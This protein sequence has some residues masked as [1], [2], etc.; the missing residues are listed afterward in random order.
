MTPQTEAIIYSLNVGLPSNVD[1]AEG[2][3]MHSGILKRPVTG[4]VHLGQLG[5]DGD[6]SADRINHGGVDKAICVYCHDHYPYWEKELSKKLAPGAFGENLTMT[7]LTEDKVHIGDIYSI[8]TAK[9]QCSQPRQ[10]CHKLNKIYGLPDMATRV[11]KCGYTGFYLRVLEP[12][13]VEPGSKMELLQ[14]GDEE[15]SIS[16]ANQLMYGHDKWSFDKLRKIIA[17]KFLSVSWKDTFQSRLESRDPGNSRNK[18]S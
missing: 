12:G 14:K 10:P 7:A 11:Q 9:V 18:G 2:Q 13:L 6:G 3:A 4:K 17:L 8:G 15:F 1:Y 16:A 5:F